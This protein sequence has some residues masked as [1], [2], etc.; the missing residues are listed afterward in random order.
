MQNCPHC[1]R[2]EQ[3][4]DPF[5]LRKR[6]VLTACVP[7]AVVG[8]FLNNM[9]AGLALYFVLVTG[10]DLLSHYVLKLKPSQFGDPDEMLRFQKVTPEQFDAYFETRRWIRC[11]S[12]GGALLASAL[13]C[14]FVPFFL[15]SVYAVITTLG[16]FFV[17]F[18]KVPRPVLCYRDDRYY[19][20]GSHFGYSSPGEYAATRIGWKTSGPIRF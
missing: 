10:T 6:I 19:V 1:G 17:R 8:F 15:C 16:I 9:L 3:K 20:P 13:S 18:L 2:P 7:A 4:S 14:H 11:V 5:V 12:L